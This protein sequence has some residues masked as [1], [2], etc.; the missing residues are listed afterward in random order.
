MQVEKQV[1]IW[2]VLDIRKK[3]KQLKIR[4][5]INIVKIKGRNADGVIKN[6]AAVD[7][8]DDKKKR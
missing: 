8:N 7:P 3:I 5:V 4:T 1:T 6:D 2:P